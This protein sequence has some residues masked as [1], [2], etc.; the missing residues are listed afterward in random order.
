MSNI[1]KMIGILG[2]V[3]VLG[4]GIENASAECPTPPTNHDCECNGDDTKWVCAKWDAPVPPVEGLDF[5]VDYACTDCSDAPE[6]RFATADDGWVL[7]SEVISSGV[8]ANLGDILLADDVN[9]DNGTFAVA[10]YKSGGFGAANVSSMVLDSSDV[11]KSLG[12]G[13]FV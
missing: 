5:A 3:V 12:S 13:I 1:Q 7:Y 8:A 6:V 9:P 10:I 2:F 4:T 11:R